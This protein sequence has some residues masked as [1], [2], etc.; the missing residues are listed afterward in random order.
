M[1]SGVLLQCHLTLSIKTIPGRGPSS[2]VYETV[3]HWY[4]TLCHQVICRHHSFVALL[5]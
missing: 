3:L 5:V 4:V 1:N 2:L